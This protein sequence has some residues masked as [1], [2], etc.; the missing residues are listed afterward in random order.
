MSF[1]KRFANEA[2]DFIGDIFHLA[3]EMTK[4][5]IDRLSAALA[6]CQEFLGDNVSL[7]A[8]L[9]NHLTDSFK[10]NIEPLHPM[11]C[12]SKELMGTRNQRFDWLADL[13]DG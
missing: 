12:Y 4:E 10:R 1:L 3:Q 13:Q 8:P 6:L 11:S 2:L 9:L 5:L 7:L